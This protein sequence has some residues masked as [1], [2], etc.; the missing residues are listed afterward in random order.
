MCSAPF[1]RV[2]DPNSLPVPAVG[3]DG[4]PTHDALHLPPDCSGSS[5]QFWPAEPGAQHQ[6]HVHWPAGEITRV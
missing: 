4:L 2:V 1:Q 3:G 5:W 6:P